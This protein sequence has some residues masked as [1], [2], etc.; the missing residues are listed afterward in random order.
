M[1]FFSYVYSIFATPSNASALLPSPLAPGNYKIGILA[2]GV[3]FELTVWLG[4][5]MK[6]SPNPGQPTLPVRA[7]P[8]RRAPLAGQQFC[9][10]ADNWAEGVRFELT[11]PRGSTV[12]KTVLLN[13][14]ST[15]PL[16]CQMS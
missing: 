10:L 8:A 6:A 9:R 16:N 1:P 4:K 15:P 2:E 12:F 11:D 13:R 5:I 14:S 3:R 7:E